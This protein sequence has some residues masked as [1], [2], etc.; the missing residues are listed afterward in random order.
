MAAKLSIA[1]LCCWLGVMQNAQAW[2]SGGHVTVARAAARALREEVPAFFRE[3]GET[4]GHFSVDPDLWKHRETPHLYDREWPEH[5][6]DYELLE[7]LSLPPLRWQFIALCAEHRKNPRDIGLLPY[8]VVEETERLAYAF[9]EHRR[10]PDHPLIRQKCLVYGGFLSHYTADLAQ[11]L[12]VTIHWDGRTTVGAQS[13]RTGI[14]NRM[15]ALIEATRIGAAELTDGLEPVVFDD[16]FASIMRQVFASRRA[17]DTVYALEADLPVLRDG[18]AGIDPNWQP[19]RRMREFALDCTRAATSLTASCWLTAW[20]KSAKIAPPPWSQ[21]ENASHRSAGRPDARPWVGL[22][23]AGL[24]I[25]ALVH[26]LG[27][28]KASTR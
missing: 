15:D 9:A 28:R 21:G 19:S 25:A 10:W 6:I 11:P 3:S 13:P 18:G 22:V 4:L 2:W 5:Y 27:K 14:H 20:V 7:G 12:H 23:I 24:L 8:S 16:L 17:I 1:V 26:R